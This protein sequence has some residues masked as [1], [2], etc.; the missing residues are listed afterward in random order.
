MFVRSPTRGPFP[1][2]IRGPFVQSPGL[3]VFNEEPRL[4]EVELD[5]SQVHI[6]GVEGYLVVL[7]ITQR[8]RC[9]LAWAPSFS[10]LRESPGLNVFTMSPV[11][12][13]QG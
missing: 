13:R 1:L 3:N 4:S 11:K 12:V 5:Y 10:R 9:Q 2:D 8:S 6:L 7:K